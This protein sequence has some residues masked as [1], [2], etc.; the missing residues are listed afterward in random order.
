[1]FSKLVPDFYYHSLEEITPSMLRS[2]GIEALV[3]DIDNTIVTY[4]D[5]LPT[6]SADR[7]FSDVTEAGIKISFVS[8]NNRERVNLF[9]SRLGYPAYAKSGKPFTKYILTAVADMGVKPEKTALIGDQIFTDILAGHRAG[10]A[11][12]IL[13]DP[14]KD[15][16][17]LFFRFK[18]L[19][20]V[21][22]KRYYGKRG[23][24]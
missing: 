9:N 19:L 2:L 11:V 16:K 10:L 3:M 6:E 8:N 4:D 14:I 15:K 23:S 22:V 1:M 18:R 21:P 12:C 7:W 20:E 17:S 24:R 5:P 13:V